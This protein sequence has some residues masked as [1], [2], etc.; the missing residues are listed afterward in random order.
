MA[1][2]GKKWEGE[3]GRNNFPPSRFYW[4]FGKPTFLQFFFFFFFWDK[5][6]G[7]REMGL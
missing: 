7:Y 1:R 2:E 4:S 6:E 5:K 3:K